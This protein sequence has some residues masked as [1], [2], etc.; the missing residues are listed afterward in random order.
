M[1]A[2]NKYYGI[3]IT[4]WSEIVLFPVVSE[5]LGR[6]AVHNSVKNG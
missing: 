2:V 5:K 1:P 4:S 3:C 6:H